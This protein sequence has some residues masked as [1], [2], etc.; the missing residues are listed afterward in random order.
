MR[1]DGPGRTARRILS[2]AALLLLNLLLSQLAFA[3][4]DF[5]VRM[6]GR[7]LRKATG[8][9]VFSLS[10]FEL[11]GGNSVAMRNRRTGETRTVAISSAY[12]DLSYSEPIPPGTL[13]AIEE[14]AWVVSVVWR[15]PGTLEA[16]NRKLS[17]IHTEQNRLRR[18]L[19][20]ALLEGGDP[21]VKV[22]SRVTLNKI[23]KFHRAAASIASEIL[24][25][26]AGNPDTNP[27]GS[28]IRVE[29]G[30]NPFGEPSERGSHQAQVREVLFWEVHRI[31]T[32]QLGVREEVVGFIYDSPAA[33]RRTVPI[34][35]AGGDGTADFVPVVTL[36]PVAV[37]A[38]VYLSR[39]GN[40]AEAAKFVRLG[41]Y[42]DPYI[43]DRAL[44][45]RLVNTGSVVSVSG[46]EAAVT[47]VPPFVRPGD[48]FVVDTGD[49]AGIPIVVA[50]VRDAEGYSLSGP[51]SAE[52]LSR[53]RQGMPV[54]RK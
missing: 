19:G 1:T 8:K 53:I 32:Q 14:D 39:Q 48:E 41:M 21:S 45:D 24:R 3:A 15:I 20:N 31:L 26:N 13:D 37:D 16:L 38:A 18:E 51:L 17:G 12:E 54:R 9:L 11:E 49:G 28:P 23:E 52:A 22:S 40:L 29:V 5:P 27:F 6:D 44:L 4:D 36:S 50:A 42:R 46:A 43:A 10:L 47:F 25:V 35:G 33:E 7:I 30:F 2:P 34:P